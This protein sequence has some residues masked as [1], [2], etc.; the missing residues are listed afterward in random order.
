MTGPSK[1][2][3]IVERINSLEGEIALS[4]LA[5]EFDFDVTNLEKALMVFIKRGTI[6]GRIEGENFI[7]E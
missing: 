1:K 4:D 6:L 7:K 5:A 3:Q 2:E